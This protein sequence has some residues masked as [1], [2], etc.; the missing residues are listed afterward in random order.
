MTLQN[1]LV[2]VI[3]EDDN[4]AA[5]IM[6]RVTVGVQPS[7][8]AFAHAPIGPNSCITING[9]HDALTNS[10]CDFVIVVMASALDKIV[11]ESAVAKFEA[12]RKISQKPLLRKRSNSANFEWCSQYDFASAIVVAKRA[13]LINMLKA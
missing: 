4:E 1:Y 10:R 11:I 12:D 13:D 5:S 2:I 6:N 7:D 8:V 9:L 3:G